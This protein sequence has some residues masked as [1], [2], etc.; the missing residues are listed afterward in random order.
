[1][2]DMRSVLGAI[3]TGSQLITEI[4]IV[5]GPDRISSGTDLTFLS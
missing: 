3:V 1:M 2:R 5:D 4:E